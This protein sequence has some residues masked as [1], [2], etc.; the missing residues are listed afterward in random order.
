MDPY[1]YKWMITTH[2]EDVSAE[3]MQK[4]LNEMF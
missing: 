4:R 3:E 2:K 1:G